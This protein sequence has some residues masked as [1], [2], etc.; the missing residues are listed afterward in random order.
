QPGPGQ[1]PSAL[2]RCRRHIERFGGVLDA[3][4]GEKPELDDPRLLGIDLLEAVQRVVERWKDRFGVGGDRERVGERHAVHPAPPLLSATGA[5]TL[6]KN[7][8]HRPRR[9]ADEVAFVVPGCAG[10]GEA[11]VSL[12]DKRRRLQRLTRAFAT[13]IGARQPAEL[14]VNERRKLLSRLRFTPFVV[15]E[16]GRGPSAHYPVGG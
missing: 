8:P 15:H 9:D 12:V 10:T 13:D 2:E 3:E 7:L 4:A 14:V 5:G 1:R 11:Q 6:N 16:P